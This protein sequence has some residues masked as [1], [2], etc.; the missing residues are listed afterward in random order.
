MGA[1]LGGTMAS[2]AVVE[3]CVTAAAETEPDGSM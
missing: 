2:E 1:G 3:A